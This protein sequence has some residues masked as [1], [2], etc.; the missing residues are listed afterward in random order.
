MNARREILVRRIYQHLDAQL[1]FDTHKSETG[2]ITK[3]RVRVMVTVTVRV[4]V[5]III[6]G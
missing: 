6:K 5:R 1:P 4:R 2:I 3:V